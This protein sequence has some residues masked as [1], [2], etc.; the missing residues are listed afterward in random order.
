MGETVGSPGQGLGWEGQARTE[1]CS[2]HPEFLLSS[3]QGHR[4]DGQ[5]HRELQGTRI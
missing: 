3:G 1:E 5:M 4:E 2:S